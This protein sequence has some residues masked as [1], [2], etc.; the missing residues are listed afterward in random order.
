MF[1]NY[2]GKLQE[3]LQKKGYPVPTYVH[4]S[5][6][7]SDGRSLLW[8]S[9]ISLGSSVVTSDLCQS[10]KEADQNVAAYVL[11]DP[12]IINDSFEKSDN[13]GSVTPSNPY[14]EPIPPNQNITMEHILNHL[15][16]PIRETIKTTNGTIVLIDLENYPQIN[17]PNFLN[18]IF[19]NIEFKGFVG[20]CSSHAQMNLSSKYP[21]VDVEI[22]DSAHKDAVDHYISMYVGTILQKYLQKYDGKLNLIILTR[23][24][25][26]GSACDA[27]KQFFPE[28]NAYHVT[29]ADE[30]M[31]LLKKL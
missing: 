30:C 15:N 7:A 27:I 20:K 23:D 8:R 24:R 11:N 12:H 21:F 14:W 2:K 9:Q 5:E 26:G 4:T 17:T 28:T 25:F 16:N 19:E 10:K 29:K 3:Y 22:V 18:S 31:E 6:K 13:L 1:T